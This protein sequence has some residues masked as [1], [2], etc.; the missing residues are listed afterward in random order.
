MNK[1][2]N[3]NAIVLEIDNIVVRLGN[4]PLGTKII[5]GISLQVRAGETLCQIGRAHV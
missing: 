1:A 2:P 5:D 3:T 4:K